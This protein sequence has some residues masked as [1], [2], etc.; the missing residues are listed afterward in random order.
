[1]AILLLNDINVY[2]VR[3]EASNDSCF[4]MTII[5]SVLFYHFRYCA[6]LLAYLDLMEFH[7][8]LFSFF[9]IET[10]V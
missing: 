2:A 8:L 10:E 7:Y 4:E 9:Q 3:I 5:T 6:F 1:M